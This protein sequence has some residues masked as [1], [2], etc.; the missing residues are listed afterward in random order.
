MLKM[1]SLKNNGELFVRDA[2]MVFWYAAQ[3]GS[4]TQIPAP[5]IVAS[6]SKR[7]RCFASLQSGMEFPRAGE[8]AA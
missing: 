6:P 8:A 2:F 1:C 4:A 7:P 3:E 5:G